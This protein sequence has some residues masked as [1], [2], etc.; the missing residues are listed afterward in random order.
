MMDI[1]YKSLDT[2]SLL[3]YVSKI[4]TRLKET[5]EL[6]FPESDHAKQLHEAR[7]GCLVELRAR[8]VAV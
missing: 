3:T 5:K 2:V 8:N 1:D 6:L 7:E 4:E